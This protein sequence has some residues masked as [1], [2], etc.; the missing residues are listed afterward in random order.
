MEMGLIRAS[1]P[2]KSVRSKPSTDKFS[3]IDVNLTNKS[4]RGDESRTT[5]S[6]REIILIELFSSNKWN[7]Y[8]EQSSHMAAIVQR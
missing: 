3:E 8:T 7:V 1:L 2:E 4:N 5:S 6:T